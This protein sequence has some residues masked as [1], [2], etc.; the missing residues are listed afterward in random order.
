S[1]VGTQHMVRVY[2]DPNRVDS[3][4]FDPLKCWQHGVQMV[5]FNYQTHDFNMRLNDAMFTGSLGYVLNVQPEPKQIR[6]GVDVLMAGGIHGL[7]AD[8]PVYV[9]LELLLPDMPS[10]RVRTTAVS[11]HGTGAVFDQNLDISMGTKYPHLAFLHWSLK[12]L[13]SNSRS[14]LI[15]SGIAKVRNLKK[16]YRLLPLGST[17]E[18]GGQ[19]LC[20]ISVSM[21]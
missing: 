19:I 15:Q 12:S 7:G 17:E 16:G 1:L 5:A 3:S 2:P 13:P 8:G 20:K 4:N 9:E 11:A 18:R 21:L 6:I 14:L 10:Q